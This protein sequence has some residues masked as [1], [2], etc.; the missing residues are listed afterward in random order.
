MRPEISVLA[1]P[2]CREDVLDEADAVLSTS[3]MIR[4]A[5]DSEAE[6]F[7][8][9]TECGLSDRLMLEV[10]DKRFFKSCQL[11]RYMK[12]IT[13]MGTRDALRSGNDEVVLSRDLCDAARG[14]IERMFE[15]S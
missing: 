7:L 4:Y 1:H 8:V 2:E 14:S 9:V 3:G 15:L 12:M 11:C 5:R 13:L 6:D 10:P